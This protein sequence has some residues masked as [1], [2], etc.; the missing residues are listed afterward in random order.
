[1]PLDGYTVTFLTAE[2]AKLI[3]GGRIDKVLQPESY[4]VVL[5]VRNHNTNFRLILNANPAAPYFNLI[6]YDPINPKQAY[7]FCMFLRKHLVGARIISFDTPGLERQI[8][9][10]VQQVNELGDT[11]NRMLM[12]ELMGRHS[13]IIFVNENNIIMNALRYIDSSVS[14]KREILPAHPYSPPPA[15]IKLSLTQIQKFWQNYPTSLK[16][17][18]KD[19][20]EMKLPDFLLAQAQGISPF[21]A[22]GLA[23]SVGMDSQHK[24]YEL[25]VAAAAKLAEFFL[26]LQNG[27][28]AP[29]IYHDLTNDKFDLHCCHFNLP[30]LS[31]S[32]AT[33]LITAGQEVFRAI[34]RQSNFNRYQ[35]L[36]MDKAEAK[37]KA[38]NKIHKILQN[39]L[40]DASGYEKHKLYGDL[41]LANLYNYTEGSDT[42]I[43][44]NYFSEN[45]ERVNIPLAVNL[46]AAKNAQAYF[47]KYN[48]NKHKFEMSTARLQSCEADL[49]YVASVI[50]AVSTAVDANDL[51]AV[52]EEMQLLK[53]FNDRNKSN[54]DKANALSKHD[55]LLHPGKPGKKSLKKKKSINNVAKKKLNCQ[56]SLPHSLPLSYRID[57]LTLW[58]GRNNLQNDRLTL[59]SAAKDDLWF[60]RKD[61]PGAHVILRTSEK[62]GEVNQATVAEAAAICAWF[63][64]KNSDR[65]QLGSLMNLE[66]VAVDYCP[67]SH[68]SKPKGSKPGRVIYR[69]YNTLYV[70]PKAPEEQDSMLS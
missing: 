21:M 13:N 17:L 57:N 14:R 67:I 24:L 51:N 53:M 54:K 52:E 20:L 31:A 32:P 44:T 62:T 65:T 68:V 43:A 22:K 3:E 40:R 56:S 19:H 6:D 58:V 25:S 42:L 16:T 34:E 55:P 9:M 30:S 35:Q 33:S 2:I 29:T 8:R 10:Q 46:S 48:K 12:F 1:M 60:H 5:L 15:Q 4:A 59:K 7:G 38:L 39:D 27:V 63:S 18:P 69:E 37:L 41:I 64:I 23:D 26:D 61:A 47:R 28:Y 66:K 11:Q 45:Q 50:S 70:V 36:L 49:A